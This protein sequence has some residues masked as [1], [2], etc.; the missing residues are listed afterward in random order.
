M[1]VDVSA[2]VG[3]EQVKKEGIGIVDLYILNAS[4]TGTD[5]LYFANWNH[6]IRGFQLNATGDFSATTELYTGLPI[7]REAIKTNLQGD[8]SGVTISIPNTDRAIEAYI[9][10][11]KYLRGCDVYCLTSFIKHLPSGNS[12][13]HIGTSQDRFAILKEKLY[14]DSTNSDENVVAFVCKPKLIIRSKILPGR[15]F[16]REC[17]WANKGRYAGTECDVNATI[18]AS[19]PSCDGTLFSCIERNNKAR[20]GGFPSIP[21]RG[22]AI[23]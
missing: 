17:A 21:N 18:V 2:T 10:N 12:A 9:Q 5:Y 22:I 13:N 8:A 14:I 1:S 15:T 16:S 3:T 6:D 4:K 11:R 23:I 7:T 19:Y 20:F